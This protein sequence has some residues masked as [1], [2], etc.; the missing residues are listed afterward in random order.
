E[1]VS[2]RDLGVAGIDRSRPAAGTLG[3]VTVTLPAGATQGP[4]TWYV[5]RL[6][7]RVSLAAG[8]TGTAVVSAATNDRTAAQIQFVPVAAGG[9]EWNA[10]SAAEPAR[11]VRT[12]TRSADVRFSNFLQKTGVRGGANTLT[13]GLE[14][15]DGGRVDRVQI[16]GDSCIGSTRRS[17][18]TLQVQAQI[19]PPTVR[20]GA[21][22]TIRVRVRNAGSGAVGTVRLSVSPAEGGVVP[23]AGTE[24]TTT[25]LVGEWVTDV[26]F[27]ARSPGRHVVIVDVGT[28]ISPYAGGSRISVP[29][30][31]PAAGGG[32]PA[33]VWWAGAAA[34][35]AGLAWWWTARRRRPHP[36]VPAGRA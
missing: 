12:A 24:R 17:P 8:S 28:A 27:R 2:L 5:I 26:R 34:P 15:F 20:T 13:F 6:H 25:D 29:V 4:S 1:C 16:F 19:N 9:M 3:R 22:F 18:E 31:A 32:V 11:R 33:A 23:L 35:V 14:T 36:D 30:T 7:A 10:V 21:D